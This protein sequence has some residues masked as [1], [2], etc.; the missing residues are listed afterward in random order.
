MGQPLGGFGS[1]G[2]QAAQPLPTHQAPPLAGT[3]PVLTHLP[4]RPGAPASRYPVAA[5]L[6]AA[7]T[8]SHVFLG[9]LRNEGD[10][11]TS[12]GVAAW[13]FGATSADVYTFAHKPTTLM[14]FHTILRATSLEVSTSQT[15]HKVPP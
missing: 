13:P 11:P 12:L 14:C 4:P 7:P 2:L 5:S 8:F 10:V 3:S 9:P 6:L 15:G 1:W